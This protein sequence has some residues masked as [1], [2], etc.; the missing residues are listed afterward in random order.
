MWLRTCS[1]TPWQHILMP[2]C[3]PDCSL[4]LW[5]YSR[6][7]I[8]PKSMGENSLTESLLLLP[9]SPF[10]RVWFI[11]WVNLKPVS[12]FYAT[13]CQD[14][15]IFI[16]NWVFPHCFR[17]QGLWLQQMHVKIL[18]C[19][20]ISVIDTP[21]L[22]LCQSLFNQWLM[23]LLSKPWQISSTEKHCKLPTMRPL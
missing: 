12:P 10:S 6:F 1:L 4:Y 23:I 15:D 11:S 2:C 20:V 14:A 13:L 21:F 17:K 7:L 16:Q 19:K 18:A 9:F 3:L 5:V 8:Y 22:S